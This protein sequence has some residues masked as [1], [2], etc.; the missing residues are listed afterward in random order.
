M[1]EYTL[2][3][4]DPYTNLPLAG[5]EVEAHSLST[6]LMIDLQTSDPRGAASFSVAEAASFHARV[7]NKPT[8]YQVVEPAGGIGS[9]PYGYDY[10]VDLN[11]ATIVAAGGGTEGQQFTTFHG[12][13]FK[14]SSTVQGALDD[15]VSIADNTAFYSIGIVKGRYVE[16]LTWPTAAQA[17]GV[18]LHGFTYFDRDGSPPVHLDTSSGDLIT[19]PSGVPAGIEATNILFDVV[20]SGSS[21]LVQGSTN[22][23]KGQ[24]HNCAFRTGPVGG[25]GTN[26]TISEMWFD[27]CEFKSGADFQAREI[28]NLF[29]S[30]CL[31]INTNFDTKTHSAAG[32]REIVIEGCLFSGTLDTNGRILLGD[33]SKRVSIVGN[34][35]QGAGELNNRIEMTPASGDD[36]IGVNI[37]GNTFETGGKSLGQDILIDASA[38]AT[39]DVIMINITN[40][41]FNGAWNGAEDADSCV[42]RLIGGA[43]SD[44]QSVI[45][46]HNTVGDRTTF[47]ERGAPAA[48]TVIGDS[49]EGCVF[50]PNTH[51]EK[52]KY[53]ITNGTD[54]LFIPGS[55][56]EDPTDSGLLPILGKDYQFS[57]DTELAISSGV[58]TATQSHHTIDTES[59][60]ATDDLDTINGLVANQLYFFY[61]ANDARTIVFKHGTGNIE[62]IGNGDI[63]LAD[64]H[65]FVWAFSP[66][67]STVYVMGGKGPDLD[68]FNGTMIEAL[69]AS[70]SEAAGVVTLSVEQAGGGDLTMRF[71]D[72]R[73]VL[74]TTP[75]ATI[76]LTVGSDASPQTNYIYI[77]QSTK[78][79]TK[80]TSQWPAAE[81]IKV[82]FL[83]VPSAV[84]V[85]ANGAYVIQQWNDFR[86]GTDGQGHMAHITER[87]RVT[88]AHWFSGIEPNGTSSYLTIVGAAVDYKSTSGVIYQLHQHASPAVD[89]SGG[90]EVL[91]KNWNGD[92]YHNITNL[93]DIVDDSGG[94]TIGNNKWF[95]IV[96][97]GVANKTGEYEPAI[98][99]LPAGFYNSQA[100]AEADLS[101][102]DDFSIP[103]E[104]DLEASVGFLIARITVQKQAGTWAFGSVV[105]LRRRG[106][107]GASG[108]ASAAATEFPDNTFQVFNVADNTKIF[109]F[110]A[111]GITTATTR[112]YTAPNADGVLALTSQADGTI[113]HDADLVAGTIAAHDTG[114]TGA[115]LDTLTDG[116]DADALHSHSG[117]SL[118]DDIFVLI[119]GD[120]MTGD[121]FMANNTGIVIG[122]GSQITGVQAGELQVLGIGGEDSMIMIGRHAADSQ[123]G[124]LDFLKGRDA[125]GTATTIVLDDD[126]L[127]GVR[128]LAADGTNFGTVVAEMQ[129]EVDDA[130]PAAN[131]IG[132]AIV[133]GVGLGAGANDLRPVLR[134]PSEGGMMVAEQAAAT[135]LATFGQYW[136]LNATPNEPWFTDD[137]SGDFQ[138]ARINQDEVPVEIKIPLADPIVASADTTLTPAYEYKKPWTNAARRMG[139]WSVKFETNVGGDVTLKLQKNGVDVASS[140]LTVASGTAES[141]T[142]PFPPQ[143]F[144]EFTIAAND[145]LTVVQTTARTDAF[146]AVATIYGYEEIVAGGDTL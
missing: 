79:L 71:S 60:A 77:P 101:G 144:T 93:F 137:A 78:V 14:V 45:F 76:A 111:S 19:F 146:Q 92:A 119:A 58:I 49:V 55:A 37:V 11:W 139:A 23:L 3:I 44:I 36:V 35:F 129:F 104:F 109:V 61:P 6:G 66:D 21:I 133:F 27:H 31:F 56:D 143:S 130:A 68:F 99:N 127:G 136:A 118:N 95:N 75:A 38:S 41:V 80:S 50:G 5:V 30:N 59:D 83:F 63:I 142:T 53:R 84:F 113:D 15:I 121:L 140:T 2:I 138:L 64:D 132:G 85:A 88:G 28:D 126:D 43:G 125:I 40:N 120:T 107:G 10:L 69:S 67:G 112:T 86:K 123:G 20:N 91:V 34:I 115:E 145:V 74:D 26:L 33:D 46:A 16:N 103:R 134:L 48:A 24:F 47:P 7:S 135:G 97:W 122:H 18:Y 54:N 32:N 128:A 81:H 89:T 70:V 124:H 17:D 106:V 96:V 116:S 65:D 57:V 82:A 13:T 72:G 39:A 102:F 131:S 114:A 4:L 110:D 108:G 1:P 52:T 51:V 117:A 98:I 94:N 29:F 12:H 141:G 62:C 87:E 42:L 9:G 73:T 90:D 100:S 22:N 25:S 8:I 105:D